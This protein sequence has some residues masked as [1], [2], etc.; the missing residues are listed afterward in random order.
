MANVNVELRNAVV[1]N[2]IEKVKILIK[3]N[4][5]PNFQ[6]SPTVQGTSSSTLHVAVIHNRLEVVR[7]L[8]ENGGD[9]NLED[10]A[11]K[12]TP[13]FHAAWGIENGTELTRLL[14][15]Y[16]GD[17]N[18]MN[19]VYKTPLMYIIKDSV[20][21]Y[22]EICDLMESVTVMEQTSV[23]G[24][25]MLHWVMDIHP[26]EQSEGFD[27]NSHFC[28]DYIRRLHRKNETT[29]LKMLH[30]L[31]EDGD[32][33][34]HV[35]AA[36]ACYDSILY[37][38]EQGADVNRKNKE[39]QTPLH[40][41]AASA[42]YSGFSKSFELL[43][44]KGAR[45]NEKD[46]TSKAPLHH[47]MYD[48]ALCHSGVIEAFVRLGARVDDVDNFGRNMI[49]SVVLKKTSDFSQSLQDQIIPTCVEILSKC[50]VDINGVDMFSLTPLHLA[51]LIKNVKVVE[52][53][54]LL[55][56]QISKTS[57]TGENSLHRS[58]LRY[59]IGPSIIANCKK[60]DILNSRDSFGSTPLHW[61]I[62]FREQTVIKCLLENG[63]DTRVCDSNGYSPLEFAELLKYDHFQMITT[64]NMSESKYVTMIDNI[65]TEFHGTDVF[66]ECPWLRFVDKID[67]KIDLTEWKKHLKVHKD[68]LRRFVAIVLDSPCM[69]MYYDIPENKTISIA[70]EAVI[71]WLAAYVERTYPLLK[72]EIRLAGS[73][74]EG[75]KV[76][77]QDEFDYLFSLINFR[78][79]F[80]PTECNLNS[81]EVIMLKLKHESNREIFSPFLTADGFLDSSKINCALYS[82]IN[83]GVLK[84]FKE[85]SNPCLKSLYIEGMLS[86]AKGTLSCL[87]FYWVGPTVKL[88][89]VSVDIVPEIIIKDWTPNDIRTDSVLLNRLQ[90]DRSVSVVMKTPDENFVPNHEKYFR[91]SFG[92]WEQMIIRS[93]PRAVTK[94]YIL[95]KA[96]LSSNYFPEIVDSENEED[97]DVLTTYKLK[98]CFLHELEKAELSNDETLSN[99][100]IAKEVPLDWANKIVS[101]LEKSIYAC[102][103]PSFFY[104]RRNLLLIEGSEI[105]YLDHEYKVLLEC[106]K[107]L[108][109][110]GSQI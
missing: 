36:C 73:K 53:I 78:Q 33:P 24:G 28:N 32:T 74:N 40:Y 100:N 26:N 55:G 60:N 68:S 76:N 91:I 50:G 39:G 16:G 90:R 72:C 107:E 108:L 86:S 103:L 1:A 4:A 19:K 84:L 101:N 96:L 52:K 69:G 18:H 27:D 2:D 21:P 42:D 41:L 15:E 5:D 59:T 35:V 51:V 25:N 85:N 14:L 58:C 81:S 88:A 38:I 82:T 7:L 31:D 92:D 70:I 48:D 66:E 80:T 43:L 97:V 102:E 89:S 56:G 17:I 63:A 106:L 9:P 98:T 77:I 104:P 20:L 57:K 93:C 22:P 12:C 110:T 37:F 83:E 45:I 67:G 75:T 95:L 29:F 6:L 62:W 64:R 105:M 79:H 13:L 46:A 109:K 30:E 8:L 34:L 61:A 94:G 10:K 54:L 99:Q 3:E 44:Q 47:A 71:Q 87:S 49:H 11:T 23:T 65:E